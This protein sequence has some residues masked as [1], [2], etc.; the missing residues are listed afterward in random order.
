MIDQ[1]RKQPPIQ[2]GKVRVSYAWADE[3]IIDGPAAPDGR[4]AGRR[5]VAELVGLLIAR[6]WLRSGGNVAAAG[7]KPGAVP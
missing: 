4:E 3:K 2:A 1:D 7:G 6:D 5:R